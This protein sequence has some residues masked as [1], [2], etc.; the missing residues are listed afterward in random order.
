[1]IVIKSYLKVEKAEDDYS[2]VEQEHYIDDGV[3][4]MVSSPYRA[5]KV[6]CP[7]Y[8]RGR[9]LRDCW[10]FDL[11]IGHGST[12]FWYPISTSKPGAEDVCRKYFDVCVNALSGRHSRP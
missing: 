9:G 1:M 7:G 11:D 10:C 3:I 2:Y 6:S 12:T 4:V 8:G 5:Y